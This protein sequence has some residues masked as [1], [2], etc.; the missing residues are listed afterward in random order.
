MIRSRAFTL[1]ELLVVIAIIALLVTILAPS[2]QNAKELAR[3]AACATQTSGM[4][5]GFLLYWEDHDWFNPHFIDRD[6]DTGE[7]PPGTCWPWA[8][9]PYMG[10]ENP[11]G[12]L[13]HAEKN[14]FAWEDP[15]FN[16]PAAFKK[17]VWNQPEAPPS[18]PTIWTYEYGREYTVG[19]CSIGMVYFTS[20]YDNDHAYNTWKG[21]FRYPKLDKL[22][23]PSKV[24]QAL[25]TGRYFCMAGNPGGWSHM[26]MGNNC[27]DP[28]HLGEVNMVFVDGHMES[29]NW[30][31]FFPWNFEVER[32]LVW[33]TLLGDRDGI[34]ASKH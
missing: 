13:S 25:D 24:C 14:H 28:R 34:W 11:R 3:K 33:P 19:T 16:C 26:P 2:L 22:S 27:Y 29:H 17:G 21:Q 7:W 4:G 15:R 12:D 23:E 8:M 6:P 10:G 31:W 30:S 20:Y 5:R 18:L 32:A 9:R 1:I